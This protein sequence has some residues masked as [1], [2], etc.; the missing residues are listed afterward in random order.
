MLPDDRSPVQAL[1]WL[2]T[3]I[4]AEGG[5]NGSVQNVSHFWTVAR[6]C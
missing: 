6:S 1:F 3:G 2:D 5:W 4:R